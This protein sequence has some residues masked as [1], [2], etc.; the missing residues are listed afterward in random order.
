MKKTLLGIDELVLFNYVIILR[1]KKNKGNGF[2]NVFS[3]A[4]FDSM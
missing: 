3:F 4:I 2:M 1:F